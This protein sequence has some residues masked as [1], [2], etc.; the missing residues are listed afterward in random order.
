VII[1]KRLTVRG[2]LAFDYKDQARAVQDLVGWVLSGKIKAGETVADGLEN[3]PAVLNRLF[4][5]SHTGKL[6]LRV[7]EDS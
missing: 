1:V 4:D 7:A 3:A 6:V 2:F 5:G